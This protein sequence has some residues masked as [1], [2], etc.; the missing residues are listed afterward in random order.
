[1]SDGFYDAL[2]DC[3]EYPPKGWG[4]KSIE[5]R[6]QILSAHF[7]KPNAAIDPWM[8]READRLGIERDLTQ[9]ASNG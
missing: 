7:A 4:W 2:R 1:M 8:E 6:R 5:R 9:E 3:G